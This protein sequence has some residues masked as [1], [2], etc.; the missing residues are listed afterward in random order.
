M[1]YLLAAMMAF[2]MLAAAQE[3]APTD[4]QIEEIYAGYSGGYFMF[5]TTGT[6]YNPNGCDGSLYSVDPESA[7]ADRLFALI[8]AAQKS[9]SKI[10]VAVD[11]NACGRSVGHLNKKIKVSR[12]K[13]L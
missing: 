8:L 4:E 13:A 12:I 5:K 2:P 1:K 7:D 11:P 9:G 6:H 3:W 10:K